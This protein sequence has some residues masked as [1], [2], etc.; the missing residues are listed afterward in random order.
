MKKY[1]RQLLGPSLALILSASWPATALA[2]PQE[3]PD[4]GY[5][6][7][8]ARLQDNEM[9]Y[10]ELEDLVKNYYG[11]IK[12]A[13]ETAVDS[14][15]NDMGD[16]SSSMFGAARELEEA[17]KDLEES[18]KDGQTPP[19]SAGAAMTE[20]YTN[21]AIAKKYRS[22]A[23]TMGLSIGAST[24]DDSKG[25]KSIQRQVNQIVYS[26]QSAM[27]GYDQLMANRDVAAKAVEVAE[28]ARDIKQAMEAQGLAV[29]GDVIGAAANLTSAKSQLESLD[30]QAQSL[31]KTLCMF[32]GWGPE[33]D[34]VMGAVPSADVAA[35]GSIDVDSD[36]EKAVNNNNTLIALRGG[37]AG[38]MSQVEQIMTKPSTQARNKLQ[39]V[40]YNENTVRSTVQTLYD[41]ILEKKASF[42]SASTAWQAAQNTW[43]AAQI[44]Y[45]NGS[46][47]KIQ[48][49]QQ[50]LAY[51]QA[52]AAYRTGDLNL[53]QAMQNY[54]W[55]VAG[56]TVN[57]E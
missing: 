13:Y 40:E 36:K 42:D 55:E 37:K 57:A 46:L 48:Y 50:E 24:R 18:V 25:M 4:T 1:S 56:L 14:S 11:P 8:Y 32:T 33:G 21:R 12:S 44:Q 26:L 47:S 30:T 49:M 35:I 31:K 23:Q 17:A 20:A 29:D 2:L 51:L 7:T 16:I 54:F 3:V 6:E 9:D 39:N 34:P 52:K 45:G 43:S 27:N 15:A 5:E 38:N 22:A 41:T 19:E 53:Q 28:A 10:N